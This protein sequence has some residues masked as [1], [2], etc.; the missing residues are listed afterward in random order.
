MHM[1]SRNMRVSDG[2]FRISQWGMLDVNEAEVDPATDPG[3]GPL[4]RRAVVEAPMKSFLICSL[5]C[6]HPGDSHLNLMLG[7]EV[8]R[9]EVCD[10]SAVG[11]FDQPE[12]CSFV[13]YRQSRLSRLPAMAPATIRACLSGEDDYC[14]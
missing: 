3:V 4:G 1:S 8:R 12:S 14:G 11:S 9:L 10:L 13:W 7:V 5:S 6:R 2:M